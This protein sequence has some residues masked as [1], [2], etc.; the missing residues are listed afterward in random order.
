MEVD[1]VFEFTSAWRDVQEKAS[2][3]RADGHV[4]VISASPQ[5]LVGEVRGATNIYQTTLI[6]EPG[7]QRIALWECGCAWAS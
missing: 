1:F 4:R 3:I 5:Y 7:S 2:K 6:R